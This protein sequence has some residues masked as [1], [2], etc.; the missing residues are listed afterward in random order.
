MQASSVGVQLP[1]RGGPVVQFAWTSYSRHPLAVCLPRAVVWTLVVAVAEPA[2]F[3]GA[4]RDL[5]NSA[6]VRHADYNFRM[7]APKVRSGDV[8]IGGM[9]GLGGMGTSS[10]SPFPGE[11]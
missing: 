6:V 11:I 1:R 2:V 4:R 8:G 7:A 3:G 5:I 9:S 10:G